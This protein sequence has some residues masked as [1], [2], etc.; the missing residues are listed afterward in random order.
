M[1]NRW[2]LTLESTNEFALGFGETPDNIMMYGFVSPDAV[3]MVCIGLLRDNQL[4]LP[5]IRCAAFLR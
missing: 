4:L 5:A 3:V 1:G 2:L